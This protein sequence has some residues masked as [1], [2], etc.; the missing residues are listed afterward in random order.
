MRQTQWQKILKSL[1]DKGWTQT[2]IANECNISQSAVQQINSGIIKE[3]RYSVGKRLIELQ[4]LKGNK[5][6]LIECE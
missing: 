6:E 5:E 4:K 1:K 3:P 2:D